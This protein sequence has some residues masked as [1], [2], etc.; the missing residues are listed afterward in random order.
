MFGSLLERPLV[1][2]DALDKYPLLV[3]MFDKELDCCKILYN[4]HIQAAEEWGEIHNK[5]FIPQK[6]NYKQ[7]YDGVYLRNMPLFSLT[8]LQRRTQS[9]VNVGVHD[10]SIFKVHL[11]T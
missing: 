8:N 4:K 1:A 11:Y 9:A 3:S 6:S 2:T 10:N 5:V 7:H